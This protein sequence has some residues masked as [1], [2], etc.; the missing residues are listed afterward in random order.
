MA[1]LKRQ[2]LLL[3]E[4]YK[5]I[6]KVESGTKLSKVA[7]KYGVPRNTIS[8]WLLPG[9]K[10]KNKS[11]FQSGEVSTKRKNVRVKQNENFEKALFG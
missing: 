10:E 7:D 6:T 3:S 11:A 1:S 2:R 9:N 8:T 5:V 4:K